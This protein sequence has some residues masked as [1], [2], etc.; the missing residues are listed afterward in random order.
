MNSVEIAMSV[1]H[2]SATDPRPVHGP[3]GQGREERIG[4]VERGK[5][6]VRRIE[7]V[8]LSEAP[9]KD[10]F[11]GDKR[12]PRG[13]RWIEKEADIRHDHDGHVSEYGAPSQLDA[14]HD[15]HRQE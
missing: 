1:A 5:A 8:E 13:K 15:E 6:V 3:R 2:A 11:T 12:G 7:V 4:D 9:R 14:S 10:V